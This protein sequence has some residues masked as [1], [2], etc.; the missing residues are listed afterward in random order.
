[1]FTLQCNGTLVHNFRSHAFYSRVQKARS[2]VV[3]GVNRLNVKANSPLDLSSGFQARPYTIRKG[4]TLHSISKKRNLTKE[5]VIALNP[6]L[7]LETMKHLFPGETILLPAG[8]LSDRDREILAGIGSGHTRIYPVR[9]GEKIAD[10]ASNR[11]IPLDK[12]K[13]LNPQIKLEQLKG[14]EKILL[15]GGYYTVR[16][17][18]MLSTVMPESSLSTPNNQ[19]ANGLIP[20][21]ITALILIAGIPIYLKKKS[22]D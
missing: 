14:G 3:R 19:V 11:N 9:A 1:M 15:P 18:E 20:I 4:D 21:V 17:K 7:N 13:E 12:I 8:T 10:I 6:K 22:S 5:Q 16:E 2:Q